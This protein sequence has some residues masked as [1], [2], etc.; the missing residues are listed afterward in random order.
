MQRSVPYQHPIS[1]ESALQQTVDGFNGSNVA[2]RL[3]LSLSEDYSLGSEFKGEVKT[4]AA[5]SQILCS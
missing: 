4:T 3:N 5:C 2:H 1:G